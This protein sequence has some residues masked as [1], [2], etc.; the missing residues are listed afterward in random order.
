VS[1]RRARSV[2]RIWPVTLS[3]TTGLSK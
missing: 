3:T 1:S 2:A